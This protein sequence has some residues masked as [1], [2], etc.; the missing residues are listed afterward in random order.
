MTSSSTFGTWET[1]EVAKA[2]AERDTLQILAP[3]APGRRLI[4]CAAQDCAPCTSVHDTLAGVLRDDTWTASVFAPGDIMTRRAHRRLGA[5]CYPTVLCIADDAVVGVIEG[6]IE[7]NGMPVLDHY[8][9]FL[10]S[11]RPPPPLDDA[12]RSNG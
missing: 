7:A 6:F 2:N 11:G 8:V 1:S 4:L 10:S 3:L 12:D 9:E 5:K